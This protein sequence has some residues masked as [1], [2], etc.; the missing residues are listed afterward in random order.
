[1]AATIHQSK[2]ER[3]DRMKAAFHRFDTDGNG[4]IGPQELRQ[5]NAVKAKALS[6]MWGLTVL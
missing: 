6:W 1:M 2:L 4:F 5:V 3:E